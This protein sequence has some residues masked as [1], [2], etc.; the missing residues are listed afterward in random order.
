[1]PHPLRTTWLLAALFTLCVSVGHGQADTTLYFQL[2]YM[3]STSPDY[4]DV[5]V[6][7]WKPIHEARIAAGAMESWTLYGVRFG[8]RSEYD[9]V[10][11][12]V[13]KGL[14]SV[15]GAFANFEELAQRV[16]PDVDVAALLTRTANT[17]RAVKSELWT[18]LDMAAG[19]DVHGTDILLTYMRVPPGGEADYLAL[20]R[21]LWKPMHEEL[22]RRKALSGWGVYALQLPGGTAYPYNFA[23]V[24]VWGGWDPGPGTSDI[25]ATVH[26]DLDWA[27]IVRRTYAAR[28]NVSTEVWQVLEHVH[29]E[30]RR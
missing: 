10:T 5:E 13:F 7:F 25:A 30:G 27:E 16:H 23:A 24:N 6:D 3:K 12:N 28:D 26:P 22:I 11:V 17:R 1:M 15:G 9:Y 21:D 29:A 8:E 19:S 2:D 18:Q 20:E 4:V 14:N